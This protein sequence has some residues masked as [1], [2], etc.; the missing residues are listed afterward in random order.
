MFNQKGNTQTSELLDFYKEIYTNLA[1]SAVAF[2]NARIK[3]N[4]E[5][6]RVMSNDFVSEVYDEENE[7][8]GKLN[9]YLITAI[10][11]SITFDREKTN[12]YRNDRAFM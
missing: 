11:G 10:D 8:M 3:F 7:S 9:G 6:L 2:Y 1:I 4:P 5:A 12:Q